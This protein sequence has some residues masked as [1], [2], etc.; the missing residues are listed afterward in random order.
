MNRYDRQWRKLT[1][2]ARAA[3]DARDTAAP[4]GFATRV[5]ARAAALPADAGTVALERFALRGLMVA[6]ALGLAA[7]GF[8][9]TTFATYTQTD[10]FV[11]ADMVG[12]L[13]DLS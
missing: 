4:Y 11:A 13:L 2:L 3:E 6:A 5:A 1:A 9:F 12:E 8:N 10:A 7:I